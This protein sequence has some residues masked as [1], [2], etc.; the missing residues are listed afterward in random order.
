MVVQKFYGSRFSCNAFLCDAD[1]RLTENKRSAYS[2]GSRRMAYI[3]IGAK[4]NE[5]REMM[6]RFFVQ[7]FR[8]QKRVDVTGNQV[9][10]LSYLIKPQ[11]GERVRKLG[12]YL[13]TLSMA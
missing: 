13:P 3:G 2:R 8:R 9:Y 4:L 11:L 10:G 12:H 1:L 6:L 5:G 7:I